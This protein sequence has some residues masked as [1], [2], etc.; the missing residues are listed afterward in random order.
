MPAIETQLLAEVAD[1]ALLGPLASALGP[2]STEIKEANLRR[3]SGEVLSSYAKRM[4]LPLVQWGDFTK[5][6]VVDIAAF[7][8][9]TTGPR[10]LNP[11]TTDGKLLTENY[12]RARKTLDEIADLQN[13]NARL[14]PDAID[15]SEGED[16]FGP[17]GAS[18]GGSRDEADYWTR[19]AGRCGSTCGG[20]P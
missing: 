18:E 3:A 11:S 20:C 7:R 13:A 16:E 8:M 5:G 12:D 14:D 6:L 17:L 9:L 10:G 2:L 1:L 19:R 4:K 15:S